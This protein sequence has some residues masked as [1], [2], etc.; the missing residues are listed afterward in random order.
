MVVT[1]AIKGYINTS[2]LVLGSGNMTHPQSLWQLT[3]DLFPGIPTISGNMNITIVGTGIYQAE[4]QSRFCHGTYGAKRHIAFL[5]A[6]R[7]IVAEGFHI[8]SLV[9]RTMKLIASV[10]EYI[11]I[12][13]TQNDGRFP[14]ETQREFTEVMTGADGFTIAAGDPVQTCIGPKLRP[15]IYGYVIT[16]VYL[17]LHAIAT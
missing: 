13:T 11:L 2:F 14:V 3:A 15:R 12:V 16:G 10:I 5:L 8:F 7:H 1:V 4:F 9:K 17:H 6:I